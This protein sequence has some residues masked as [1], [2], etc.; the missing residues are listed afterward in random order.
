MMILGSHPG[1]LAA[2]AAP[3]IRVWRWPVLM[4]G[5]SL[6][7][8]LS[9][10]LG[11]GGVW[12]ILSWIALGRAAHCHRALF[13]APSDAQSVIVEVMTCLGYFASKGL[14]ALAC[15]GQ[16]ERGPVSLRGS[17]L[18]RYLSRVRHRVPDDVHQAKAQ[19]LGDPAAATL[20]LQDS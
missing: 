10:L 4:A 15:D 14:T 1:R 9:A 2:A 18:C 7:G 8:L 20:R 12:W 16:P 6:F 17:C 3:R 19:L 13:V 11:Q 5:L